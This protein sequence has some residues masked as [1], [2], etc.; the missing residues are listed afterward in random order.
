MKI[1][2]RNRSPGARGDSQRGCPT[3][4]VESEGWS[5]RAQATP[6]GSI[7]RRRMIETTHSVISIVGTPLRTT[8]TQLPGGISPLRGALRG[9]KTK[10]DASPTSFQTES[11]GALRRGDQLDETPI[12]VWVPRRASR[13]ASR[14]AREER[15]RTLRQGCDSTRGGSESSLTESRRRLRPINRDPA[16]AARV[17]M[18]TK[19]NH[20][21]RVNSR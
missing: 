21:A 16:C 10:A 3:G 4:S 15:I 9:G 11:Y 17:L 5:L 18:V 8:A 20:E 14:E 19:V 6:A 7:T 13:P 1:E 2:T 12:D